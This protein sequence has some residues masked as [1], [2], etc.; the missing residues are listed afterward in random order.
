MHTKMSVS[1]GGLWL[2]Y[3]DCFNS[4]MTSLVINM[5]EGTENNVTDR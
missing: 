1:Y 2:Y 3:Q 4:H 5:E